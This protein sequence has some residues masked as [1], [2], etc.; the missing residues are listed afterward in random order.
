MLL[1]LFPWEAVALGRDPPLDGA[2]PAGTL[3]RRW[4][5]QVFALCQGHPARVPESHPGQPQ[6][7]APVLNRPSPKSCLCLASWLE[8]GIQCL[9]VSSGVRLAVGMERLRGCSGQE[10]GHW[11]FFRATPPHMKQ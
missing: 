9:S 8:L 11:G 5:W 1:P 4:A 3:A 7:R 10:G 6:A 2:V